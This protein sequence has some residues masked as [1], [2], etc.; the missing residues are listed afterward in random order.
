VVGE[1]TALQHELRDHAV[2]DG[3]DVELVIHVFHKVCHAQ[4]SF[5]LV[6]FDLD[7][8]VGCFH[9]HDGI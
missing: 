8:T 3:I 2:E 9:H 5:L 4:G 1:V 7:G 6:E